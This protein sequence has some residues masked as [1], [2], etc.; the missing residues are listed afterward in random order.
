MIEAFESAVRDHPEI[1]D[2]FYVAGSNDYLIRFT[3]NDAADLE[4]FHAEVLDAPARRAALELDA[5]A[6]RLLKKRPPCV[7]D[8]ALTLT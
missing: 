6:A 1:L 3:Y 8:L 7:S 2:C 4:R 5:G